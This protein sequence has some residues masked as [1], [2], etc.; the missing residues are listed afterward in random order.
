MN[1]HKPI[2][3]L[4]LD[5]DNKWS[6]LKTHGDRGWEEFP[7]YLDKLVPRVLDFLS[8]RNLQITFFVIGQDAALEENLDALRAISERGHEIGNHSF[9]HEP[10]MHLYDGD[11][12]EHEIRATEEQIEKITGQRTVGF[13]GPGFSFSDATLTVLERR[14]YLYDA[15]TFPTYL[16]PLARLY[17][18]LHSNLAG[19]DRKQR[20]ALFGSFSNGF[21]PLKP[22][23][24]H[25]K[26]GLLEIPVTTMPMLRL[27]IHLSYLLFLSG[28][29]EALALEYFRAALGLCRLT[30]V[31]PSLLLHSL[32]FLGEEDKVGLDFF[33][34]LKLRT[35]RKLK[36]V[37]Q[38]LRIYSEQFQVLDMRGHARCIMAVPSSKTLLYSSADP[39]PA[40]EANYYDD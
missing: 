20:R 27:P 31:S 1:L 39:S 5:L 24:W 15:S 38:V 16:G 29:S 34:G 21:R 11:R 28:F 2:A 14:H 6:Y 37:G 12:V 13:R 3:S 25:T 18:F 26:D 8:E 4:S 17:Y 35:I 30:G 9:S 10:W 19:E 7:S 36:F 22:Y 33:P 23:R 40:P 32:D